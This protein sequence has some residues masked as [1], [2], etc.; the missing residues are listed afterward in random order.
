MLE[1]ISEV[2]C[3]IGDGSVCTLY[4]FQPG[5]EPPALALLALG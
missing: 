1:Q 2:C 4:R 5:K 3:G